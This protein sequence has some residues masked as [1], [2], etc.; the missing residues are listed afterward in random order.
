MKFNIG[1]DDLNPGPISSGVYENGV[2]SVRKVNY[3]DSGIVEWEVF[4]NDIDMLCR[5]ALINYLF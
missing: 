1:D 3:S 2:F 4:K 5:K